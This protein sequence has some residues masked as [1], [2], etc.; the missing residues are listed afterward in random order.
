MQKHKKLIFNNKKK[1]LKTPND[2][3]PYFQTYFKWKIFDMDN[4][5]IFWVI[6]FQS[7]IFL[8]KV[9]LL[10]VKIKGE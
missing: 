7:K 4:N 1:I 3:Q 10:D 6:T 9:Y 2:H 5:N 8:F